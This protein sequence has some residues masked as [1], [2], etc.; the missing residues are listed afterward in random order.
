MTESV[1]PKEILPAGACAKISAI[2]SAS[3]S[4]LP[5]EPYF[6][7]DLPRLQRVTVPAFSFVITNAHGRCVLFDLGLRKDWTELSPTAVA[8]VYH[9]NLGIQCEKD[10]RDILEAHEVSA[11][12]V[13]AIILSHHHFDHIGDPSRFPSST[14][15][16]VGPGVCDALMPGYPDQENAEIL[17]SDYSNRQV[18]EIEFTQTGL[19]ILGLPALDY[20]NDGSLYLL[21]TPGHAVGHMAALVRTTTSPDSFVLLGGDACHHCG[22]LRPSTGQSLPVSF[23]SSCLARFLKSQDLDGSQP[24]FRIQRDPQY[25]AYCHDSDEAEQTIAHLQRFDAMENIFIIFAHD[26]SL[27]T[28]IDEFPATLNDWFAKGWGRSGRW[29]FLQDFE[30]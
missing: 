2:D 14:A 17:T 28:V 16:V 12:S 24:F 10:V 23:Q 15:L 22:E 1:S 19:F 29:R 27:K 21:S 9:D 3:L 13:E 26:A 30:E 11:E 18:R 7:S 25:A 5:L 4:N 20:F 8:E 6:H